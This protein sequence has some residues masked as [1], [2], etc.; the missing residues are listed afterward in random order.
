MDIVN[1][2]ALSLV[3]KRTAV[4]ITAMCIFKWRH[5]AWS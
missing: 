2:S 1:F 4:I 5:M 3:Q